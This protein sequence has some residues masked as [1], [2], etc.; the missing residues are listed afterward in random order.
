MVG[1][2]FG[3]FIIE[4]YEY[5]EIKSYIE[6]TRKNFHQPE[7]FSGFE[8]VAKGDREGTALRKPCDLG[9]DDVSRPSG[10]EFVAMRTFTALTLCLLLF[11]AAT[12]RAADEPPSETETLQGDTASGEVDTSAGAPSEKQA[13]VPPAKTGSEEQDPELAVPYRHRPG[14]CPEGPPCK[15][16]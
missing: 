10:R 6:R 14:A 15:T 5:P 3:A 4:A 11:A 12:A 2:F 8:T 9:Q 13:G 16:D 7:A 1:H